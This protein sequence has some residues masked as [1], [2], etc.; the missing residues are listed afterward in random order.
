MQIVRKPHDVRSQNGEIGI[1]ASW[2]GW[3]SFTDRTGEPLND[4]KEDDPEMVI[5][6]LQFPGEGI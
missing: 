5:D 2:L 4:L 6:F 3:D 1:Q